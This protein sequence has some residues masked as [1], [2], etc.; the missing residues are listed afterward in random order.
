MSNNSLS[1]IL[2]LT[3]SGALS[4]PL[5]KANP[6][7]WSY[8]P[9]QE[10]P[11]LAIQSPQNFSTYNFNSSVLLNFT[12]TPP[13]SWS[14][15]DMILHY[16]GEIDSVN[17]YM[18]GNLSAHYKYSGGFSC[19][20]LNLNQSAV[21]VHMIN[22]TVLSY[23]YYIGQV[24]GNSA[25]N[26]SIWGWTGWSASSRGQPIWEY[27]IVVSDIVYFDIPPKISIISMENRTYTVSEVPLNLTV[28]TKVSKLSYVLDGQPNQTIAG[29]TT[30]TGLSN[31][32]HNV[33]VYA[34]DEA[35]N[36]GASQTINFTVAKP[37]EPF[38]T[39]TVAVSG[40]IAVIAVIIASS[41]LYRRHRRTKN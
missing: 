24:Y 17:V 15:M 5:T 25:I 33:T 26:S 34:T 19:V 27:L 11:T 20:S 14:A 23:T 38:P 16:V 29:N 40:V 3:V 21:G 36:I 39:L 2:I 18:D 9:N 41:L 35:E 7:P 32:L 13:D 37:A 6:V 31:G 12:A 4:M 1:L 8:T 10:R 30:L 22:V 28:N